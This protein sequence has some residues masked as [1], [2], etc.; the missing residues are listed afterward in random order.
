MKSIIRIIQKR[1][2]ERN[3]RRELKNDQALRERCVDYLTRQTQVD[4]YVVDSIVRYIKEG[5]QFIILPSLVITLV[6]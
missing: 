6:A 4:R 3:V 5:M 1:I 2:R